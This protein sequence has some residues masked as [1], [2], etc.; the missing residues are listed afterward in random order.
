LFDVFDVIHVNM[1]LIN[2][3]HPIRHKWSF[4]TVNA[5]TVTVIPRG[6]ALLKLSEIRY[7]SEALAD[8]KVLSQPTFWRW[9]D[10]AGVASGKDC[11]SESE[12]KR[13]ARIA[14]CYRMGK[15]T[16]QILEELINE[17]DS[18]SPTA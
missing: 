3:S 1:H 18:N 17:Q 13:L 4:F 11:F 15:N 5:P 7:G 9:I 14:R 16:Q 10:L 8:G 2:H 12:F 6:V